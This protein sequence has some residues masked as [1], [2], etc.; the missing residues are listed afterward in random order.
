[1]LGRSL[2]R[3]GCL[4]WF[5]L[6]RVVSFKLDDCLLEILERYAK[7][8]N[9]IKSE[10]IRKALRQYFTSSQERPFVTYR[11]RIYS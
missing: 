7:R 3:E 5:K 8:K 2:I 4:V 9:L 6:L 11:L 1:M 10:V